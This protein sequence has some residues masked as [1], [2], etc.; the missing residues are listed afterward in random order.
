ML[1]KNVTFNSAISRERVLTRRSPPA[2]QG[3]R[4]MSSAKVHLTKRKAISQIERSAK[5]KKTVG[6]LPGQQKTLQQYFSQGSNSNAATARPNV[7]DDESR[8]QRDLEKAIK[9]S[10]AECSNIQGETSENAVDNTDVK[11]SN[12][13]AQE[14]NREI[15][16]PKATHTATESE[17]KEDE[18]QES[19]LWRSLRERFIYPL[20]EIQNKRTSVPSTSVSKGNKKATNRK[21]P[22]YKWMQGRYMP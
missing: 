7:V 15:S 17:N 18:P 5:K 12:N 8:F 1:S 13:P 14:G 3:N 4:T 16:T 6:T 21:C 10:L 9:L 22:F 2:A 20:T 11:L 19:S